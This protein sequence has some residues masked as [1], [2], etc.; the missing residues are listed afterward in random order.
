VF[1]NI[2]SSSSSNW[3]AEKKESAL[4]LASGRGIFDVPFPEIPP[5]AGI[6]VIKNVVIDVIGHIKSLAGPGTSYV[7]VDNDGDNHEFI[8]EFV[9][10]SKRVG[11]GQPPAQRTLLRCVT[12][13]NE[14]FKFG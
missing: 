6:F 1:I 11:I 14:E 12:Y 9:E 13:L 8:Q 5:E 3:T 2:G 10:M 4:A 7:Y